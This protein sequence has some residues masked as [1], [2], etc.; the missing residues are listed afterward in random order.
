MIIGAMSKKAIMMA[1]IAGRKMRAVAGRP[2]RTTPV[3]IAMATVPTARVSAKGTKKVFASMWV[4][5][6]GRQH[7]RQ[8]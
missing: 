5:G 1:L 3:I 2:I 4:A 6:D 8:G 7:G